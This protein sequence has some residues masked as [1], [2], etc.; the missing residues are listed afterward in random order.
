MDY[1]NKFTGVLTLDNNGRDG[2]HGIS[3]MSGSNGSY[4]GGHGSNGLAGSHG[5]NGS[6]AVPINLTLSC[7]N[8]KGKVYF[9]GDPKVEQFYADV[10]DPTIEL[11]LLSNGGKGGSG[12]NIKTY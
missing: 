3:G 9:S 4:G 11:K 2:A 7:D 8:E 6:P 10:G 1:I 5:Q 12:G